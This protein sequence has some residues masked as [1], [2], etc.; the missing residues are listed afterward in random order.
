MDVRMYD[1]YN[2][3]NVYHI[4]YVYIQHSYIY[5]KMAVIG[6]ADIYI[7]IYIYMHDS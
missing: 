2:Y 5:C 3:T 4:M 1:T 6:L 7:Y